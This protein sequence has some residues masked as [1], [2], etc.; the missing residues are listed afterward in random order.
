MILNGIE[1]TRKI[2]P[3]INLRDDSD[4]IDDFL[5]RAQQ[6]VSDTIIGYGLEDLLDNENPE[7]P[8]GHGKLRLLV[9]RVIAVKAY[10]MFADEMNLQL[11]EA[12]MTVQNNSDMNAASS[13]RR[14][15]L[16]KSLEDRMDH[17]CDALVNFLL[18]NS[19]STD[20]GAQA[21]YGDWRDT[22]QFA[23][24]S[25]AFV[26]TLQELR[27]HLPFK[28]EYAGHW[29]AFSDSCM[30]MSVGMSDAA[31]PYVSMAEIVRLR[32][33][34]REGRLN[35]V[36]RQAVFRLQSVAAA[37][38]VDDQAQARK[39]AI[40]ARSIM[41]DYLEEFP[42]FAESDCLTLPGVSFNAGHIVDTL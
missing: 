6:W 21:A 36:Q 8:D 38:L 25:V 42:S 37:C 29:A 28:A 20:E 30:N 32:D 40:G 17:D 18:R 22:E 9:K 23:N 16:M 2:L 14:D 10:I 15:N 35:E 34:Y 5:M 39:S 41:L 1:E 19:V 31:S 3:S 24:L 11:G 13:A 12:G 4:R 26:P 33:L 7:E 27:R